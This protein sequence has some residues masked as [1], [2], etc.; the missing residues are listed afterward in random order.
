MDLPVKK[1][2]EEC[3]LHYEKLGKPLFGKVWTYDEL[4]N[5]ETT[6]YGRPK[7]HTKDLKTPANWPSDTVVDTDSKWVFWLPEGWMQGIRTSNA[8]KLLKCY[9]TPEGKRYWHKKDVQ[10][11]VNYPLPTTD[12]SEKEES[13]GPRIRYVTDED[14]I[15]A[16][17][18]ENGVEWLPQDWRLVFR[19]LPSGLHKCYVPPGQ[20]AGFCYHKA[21]VAEFL[22][23]N[24]GK[25]SL[26]GGSRPMAEVV[27]Q[28]VESG[29]SR[30]ADA[31]EFSTKKRKTIH[32]DREIS[33]ANQDFEE[34]TFVIRPV[35]N[36][37]MSGD[38]ASVAKTAPEIRKVLEKRGFKDVSLI[39]VYRPAPSKLKVLSLAY[40]I[41]FRMPP[42][43]SGEKPYWQMVRLKGD[44]KLVC[45]GCY[46]HWNPEG[47]RWQLG[48]MSPNKAGFAWIAEESF[49]PADKKTTWKV[50]KENV[51]DGIFR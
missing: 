51:W 33:V 16:W 35:P 17:P 32:G 9:F 42:A 30:F 27:K 41:Y 36:G 29:N 28:A 8:G 5:N 24:T 12:P 19:Q 49:A 45:R 11:K 50:L 44:G 2:E 14:S 40:G 25:L 46:L 22:A 13:E 37:P 21:I 26:F 48:A 7:K 18:E 10:S 34:E 15:P 38:L 4:M 47:K 23:G 6:R 43:S 3:R 31:G 20:D 39:C 1:S